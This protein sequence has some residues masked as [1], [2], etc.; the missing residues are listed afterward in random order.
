MAIVD[1]LEPYFIVGKDI[2]GG[3]NSL[4][5][6]LTNSNFFCILVVNNIMGNNSMIYY[7]K[8]IEHTLLPVLPILS[9]V[10]YTK[11]KPEGV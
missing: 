2:L 3:T 11:T 1:T 5:C 7:V 9:E 4:L 8:N 10:V 6:S